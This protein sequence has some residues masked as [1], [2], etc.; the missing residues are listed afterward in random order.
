L[1]YLCGLIFS[2]RLLAKGIKHYNKLGVAKYAKP[3]V[4]GYMVIN[5]VIVILIMIYRF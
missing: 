2:K 4:F 5:I 1:F 3:I